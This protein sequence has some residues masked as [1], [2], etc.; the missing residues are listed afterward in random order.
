MLST[1]LL[2]HYR[3]V[4]QQYLTIMDVETT[5]FTPPEGRVIEVSVLQAS[6]ADGIQHQQTHLINPNVQI[7]EKISEFTGISQPMIDQAPLASEVW[8]KYLPWLTVGVLTAHNLAFDYTFIQAE[9]ARLDV[10][11]VRPSQAQLCTVVL[12][13]LML[14]ELPSRSLPD[15]VKYFGFP[16]GRS[17][18]AEADTLACW[19]LAERLLTEIQNE[20]DEILLS[21]F[22]HQW[23]PLGDAAALLGC[24]GKQARAYLAEAGVKPRLVG[25]HKTPVYQRGAVERVYL[26]RSQSQPV[27]LSWL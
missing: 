15:L 12:A 21:R 22:A 24:S 26:A 23:L 1:E 8:G 18:R 14:P 5:G 16:I 25:R 17:H 27:Q 2:A 19:L 9:F 4:S 10:S 3:Q 20:S 11:F 13:R 7:P 6:L